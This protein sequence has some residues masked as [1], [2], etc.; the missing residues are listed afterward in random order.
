VRITAQNHG[1]AI[2]PASLPG[3]VEVT[4]ISGNDRTCEGLR[5]RELPVF[6]VQYHPEA[7]PGPHDGDEHFRSFVGMLG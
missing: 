4:E 1:F 5:H 2:D 6:S 7:G 3:A